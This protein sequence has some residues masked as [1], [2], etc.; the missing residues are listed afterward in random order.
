[1][2]GFARIES[3]EVLKE[4]R[5][6]LCKFS[7]R[8]STALDEAGSEINR[9]V[10]WLKQDQYKH[11]KSQVRSRAERAT[12]AK[13]VLQSKQNFQEVAQITKDSCI[14]EKKA[15]ALAQKKLEE[16]YE[17]LANV[18]RW[19]PIMEKEAFSYQGLVQG[20]GNAIETEI[21]NACAQIDR[22]IDSLEA[23]LALATPVDESVTIAT[24][25]TDI[26]VPEE[27]LPSLGRKATTPIE[28]P[29]PNYQTLRKRTPKLAVRE[30]IEIENPKI[31]WLK[32]GPISESAR[33]MI[34]SIEVER[35][36]ISG[37]DKIVIA[38]TDGKHRRIYLE[39]IEPV[40]R[41]DSGW[42]IGIAE[43]GET[44]GYEGIRFEKLQ[45]IRPD[46]NEIFSLP[47]GYLVVLGGVSI[48]AVV[49]PQ[50]NIMR[51]TQQS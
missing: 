33:E 46:L 40:N 36:P 20:L 32:R 16:A 13:L 23:Y 37:R 14:D 51:P 11:W 28:T 15:L 30:K 41:D 48:E 43:G 34:A 8:V 42:Y 4:F 39:R 44:G 47:V 29:A 17:K 6:V 31:P 9:T 27:K 35:A 18:R 38:K 10:R 12:Q 1:M 49:D 21:P 45:K 22:M 26:Q 50:D 2:K 19:I 25:E 5:S 24:P 3:V 7:E